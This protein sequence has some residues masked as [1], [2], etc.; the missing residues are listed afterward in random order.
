[1]NKKIV[2]WDRTF[3]LPINFDCYD[4]E[5]ILDLQLDAIKEFKLSKDS[6]EECKDALI[7]RIKRNGSIDV[8]NVFKYVRPIELYVQRNKKKKIVG[9]ICAYKLDM[10]HGLALVFE[11]NNFSKIG[12]QDVL[13]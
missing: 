2:I 3:N 5:E 11:N 13:Y 4:D 8:D 12:G 9:I 1:M 10:E 7:K 6:Q